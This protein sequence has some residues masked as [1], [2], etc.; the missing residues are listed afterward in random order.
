[1]SSRVTRYAVHMPSLGSE[2]QGFGPLFPIPS[3]HRLSCFSPGI[4]LAEFICEAPQRRGDLLLRC[5]P[6]PALCHCCLFGCGIVVAR[7]A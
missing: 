4:N 5:A 6:W 7:G 2:I 3:S 1:M